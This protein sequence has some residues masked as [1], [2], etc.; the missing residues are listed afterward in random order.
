M[1]AFVATGYLLTGGSALS[2]AASR[3]QLGGTLNAST[4]CALTLAVLPGS[5]RCMRPPEQCRR[6]SVG[7]PALLLAQCAPASRHA[8]AAVSVLSDSVGLQ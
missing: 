5:Q 8:A 6:S 2:T 3:R 1:A 4:R 7:W